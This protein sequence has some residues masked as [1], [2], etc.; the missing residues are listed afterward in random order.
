VA[1]RRTSGGVPKTLAHGAQLADRLVELVGLGREH[2]S[3]D[4][5][6]PVRKHAHNL[7]E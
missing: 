6:P 3:V 1:R 4:S 7:F 2:L 5:R